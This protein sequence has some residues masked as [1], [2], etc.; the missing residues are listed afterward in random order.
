MKIISEFKEDIFKI[1]DEKY[2][3]KMTEKIIYGGVGLALTTLAIA[4]FELVIKK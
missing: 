1:A 4:I 2:A 3:A